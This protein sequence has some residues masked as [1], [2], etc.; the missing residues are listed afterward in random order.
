MRRSK[1]RSHLWDW[2]LS[3]FHILLLYVCRTYLHFSDVNGEICTQLFGAL[4]CLVSAHTGSVLASAY[5]VAQCFIMV[6]WLNDHWRLI[7][8]ELPVFL[9]CFHWH[10]A[11]SFI[12]ITLCSC[13]ALA[14]YCLCVSN[15]LP[16]LTTRYRPLKAALSR[17]GPFIAISIGTPAIPILW[18]QKWRQICLLAFS[19]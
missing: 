11:V 17:N 7:E 3:T 12:L 8:F 19:C 13:Q 10:I 14:H 2:Q 16:Q 4:R 6:R 1:K 15:W 18:W 5:L 9:F